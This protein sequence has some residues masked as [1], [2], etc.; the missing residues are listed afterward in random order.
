[1]IS[2]SFDFTGDKGN[3]VI[4]SFSPEKL[5]NKPELQWINDIEQL[6]EEMKDGLRHLAQTLQLYLKMEIQDA[7]HLPP[8]IDFFQIFAKVSLELTQINDR[9]KTGLGERRAVSLG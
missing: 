9:V 8:A 5:L 4:P 1:M 3:S 6:S 7:S 2:A